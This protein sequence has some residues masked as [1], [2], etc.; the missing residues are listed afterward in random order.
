VDFGQCALPPADIAARNAEI[1]ALEARYPSLSIS[2][3]ME[4]SLNGP[5][6]VRAA[7]AH[8]AGARVDF[9][10][11]SVHAVNGVD[12]Y[13]PEYYENTTR[14]EA[15]DRYLCALEK[16]VALG[17]F[18]VMGHYDF[19][20]KHAPYEECAVR[21]SDHASRFDAIFKALVCDGR[22]MEVN[23]S[24]WHAN[25]S[26]GLDVLTRYRELGGEFVTVGSD[27]HVSSRVGR[28][29]SE[30][31]EMARAAGIKYVATFKELRPVMHA[32]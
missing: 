14:F 1:S 32:L 16:A 23:T 31:V 2:R 27:A 4:I 19:C 15:Y 7:I 12:A 5:A 9:I 11:G 29:I 18:S 25:P 3:G 24:A 17:G 28:R 13:Y 21:Y 22:G 6:E 8:A 10:I 20:A 30:A 26:W